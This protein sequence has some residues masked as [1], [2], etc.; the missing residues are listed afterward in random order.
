MISFFSEKV[1]VGTSPDVVFRF[2]PKLLHS[3]ILK[4]DAGIE[5][6]D[7]NLAIGNGGAPLN[8]NEGFSIKWDD[9]DQKALSDNDLVEIR[10]VAAVATTVRI[11]RFMKG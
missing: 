10:G 5:L 11:F 4:A 6:G 8:A 9:F 7:A 3:A 2:R 1:V